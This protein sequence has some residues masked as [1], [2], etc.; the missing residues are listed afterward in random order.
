MPRTRCLSVMT[1]DAPTCSQTSPGGRITSGRE[2]VTVA[3]GSMP[4]SAAE[5]GGSHLPRGATAP[6]ARLGGAVLET[7]PCPCLLPSVS[8]PKLQRPKVAAS[9]EG[10]RLNEVAR[11]GP[12]PDG[13]GVLVRERE[14][15]TPT[16]RGKAPGGGEEVA[17][18]QA[19]GRA[20]SPDTESAGTP[21]LDSRPPEPSEI[22]VC[23]SE[24]PRPVASG[25]SATF[26]FAWAASS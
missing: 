10:E 1:T 14:T 7:Q 23:R 18:R 9:G 20:S 8:L 13:P 19:P 22:N 26:R 17:V 5:P 15:S 6:R 24:V 3:A 25:Y 16:H 4:A 21:R 12:R 2:A 11:A